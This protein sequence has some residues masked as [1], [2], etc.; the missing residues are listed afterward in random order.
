MTKSLF[1]LLLTLAPARGAITVVQAANGN[2]VSA[3]ATVAITVTTGNLLYVI[4]GFDAGGAGC[5]T[6]TITMSDTGSN[7]Y[8]AISGYVSQ[9]YNCSRN[10]YVA[11]AT[12]G[13]I[14]IT[15]ATSTEPGYKVFVVYEVSGL[16]TTSPLDTSSSNTTCSASPCASASF[17]TAQ[18]DEI[19]FIS[20]T[21]YYGGAWS[22]GT[23]GG[24]AGT[25]ASNGSYAGGTA[26][27]NAASSYK[28][29]TSTQSSITGDI[30]Q[31]GTIYTNL[32]MAAFKMAAAGG[33][34]RRGMVLD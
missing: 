26:G 12:G 34:K 24:A 22:A 32:H 28:I 16:A 27:G 31:A 4:A 29:F 15:M 25:I 14:T 1:L 9:S 8:T 21:N 19:V 20:A 6:T 33:T 23:I 3:A 13:S 7:T 2:N 10:Y 18:A 17:S 5:S 30:A 11:N